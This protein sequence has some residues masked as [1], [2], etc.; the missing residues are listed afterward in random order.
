MPDLQPYLPSLVIAL[1]LL[2]ILVLLILTFKLFNQRVRGRRG[3][4]LGISEFHELDKT[5]RLVLVRRD[6]VEHLVLIGGG[7]DIVIESGIDSG[8]MRDAPR[9]S[10]TPEADSVPMRPT[11]PAVFGTRRPVLR[12]VEPPLGTD[13][14]GGPDDNMQR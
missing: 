1:I 9:A 14:Q 2:V 5:R 6:A 12:T 3:Q 11:R 10:R 8:L 13:D 7:Q 4:R